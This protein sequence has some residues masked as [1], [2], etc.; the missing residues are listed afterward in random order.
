[1]YIPI[2]YYFSF[3]TM[4]ILKDKLINFLFTW[5]HIF[6]T[7]FLFLILANYCCLSLDLGL[8]SRFKSISDLNL[9]SGL[10]LV[11]D[12]DSSPLMDLGFRSLLLLDLGSEFMVLVRESLF[13]FSRVSDTLGWL[14]CLGS[15]NISFRC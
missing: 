2:V 5:F 9:G 7:V 14:W 4:I 13:A 6:L 11:T 1:M 3:L 15:R 10:V 12:T 8:G